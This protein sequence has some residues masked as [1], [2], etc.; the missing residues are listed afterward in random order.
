M[1][2]MYGRRTAAATVLGALLMLTAVVAMP[3]VA[4]AENFNV[5]LDKQIIRGAAGQSFDLGTFPTPDALVGD[6]CTVEA[7]GNNNESVHIGNDIMVTSANTVTLMGVE[8]ASGKDTFADGP[9]TLSETVTFT[10]VL[11]D[12]AVY[13]AEFLVTFDCP[14][15]EETTTTTTAQ[16]TTSTT[17]QETT[18]TTVQETTSTTVD[19][20][21]TSTIAPT[22][23]T[24]GPTATTAPPE[25]QA[26]TTV[27]STLP[28]TGVDSDHLAIVAFL[29]LAAGSGLVLMTRQNAEARGD[30]V[31]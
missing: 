31:G 29:A 10:L 19:V 14:D 16:E 30:R 22:T 7:I 25:V 1:N 26:T 24:I 4:A 21:T 13:S 5:E 28:F 11:G 8:D 9:L 3:L 18:S 12:D 23:T 6:T 15:V 27:P 20:T 17:V 2:T